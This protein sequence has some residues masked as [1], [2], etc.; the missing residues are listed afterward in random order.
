MQRRLIWT[1]DDGTHNCRRALVLGSGSTG[2]LLS[3]L[4]R[5]YGFE[6]YIANRRDPLENESV[7]TEEA[8]VTFIN[9]TRDSL[10]RLKR[11]GFDL[12]VDTTGTSASL[13]RD[14]VEMLRPNGVLGLFGFPSSG[15]SVIPHDVW[16][17]FIH[18]SNVIVGLANGQKPHFQMALSHL[19][20]WKSIWPRATRRLITKTIDINNEGEVMKALHEKVKGE[21]K[22]VIKW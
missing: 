16:Q 21:I 5:T 4:L 12:V 20:Q 9:Y 22:V 6:V 3:L 19:A 8:G 1:C 11:V 2:T 14:A 13:I 10:D 18:K 7:I 17:R 15:E